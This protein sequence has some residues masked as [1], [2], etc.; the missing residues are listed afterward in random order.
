MINKFLKVFTGIIT[1]LL[2]Q[3][4]LLMADGHLEQKLAD[5]QDEIDALAAVIEEG[6]QGEDG[7]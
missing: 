5:M 6:G 3:T 7:W 1:G 4:S 2:F